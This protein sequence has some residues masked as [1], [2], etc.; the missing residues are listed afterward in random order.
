MNIIYNVYLQSCG[1]GRFFNKHDWHY[2]Y[3]CIEVIK[4][5]Q[6]LVQIPLLVG[7]DQIERDNELET[8]VVGY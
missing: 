7:F 6:N 1:G 4:P 5:Y 2:Q 3:D 8:V